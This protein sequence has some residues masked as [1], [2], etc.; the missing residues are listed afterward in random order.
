M[1]LLLYLCKADN[2][3]PLKNMGAMGRVSKDDNVIVSG[4]LE[5]LQ[6]VM[7]AVPIH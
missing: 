7:G 1:K 5:K 2:I 4:I 6:H 3:Q